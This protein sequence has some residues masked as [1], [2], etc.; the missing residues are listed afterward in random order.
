MDNTELKRYLNG[1]LLDRARQQMKIEAV[2][3]L[4][5]HDSVLSDAYI[6]SL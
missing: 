1:V 4:D 6:K 2:V 3:A 5:G